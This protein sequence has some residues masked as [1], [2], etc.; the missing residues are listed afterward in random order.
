[1]P[2]G[3]TVER[4][5]TS[6]EMADALKSHFDKTDVCI[7]AAAISD[8]SPRNYSDE[9]IKRRDNGTLSIDL[10][11]NQDIAAE[12]AK[13]KKKQF[14][15]CFSLETGDD[16]KRAAEKMKKKGCDMM[17]LNSVDS[18][19]GKEMTSVSILYPGETPQKIDHMSKRECAQI[20]LSSIAEK[21]GFY[22]G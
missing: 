5:L 9:K 13:K 7:M 11:P 22:N 14:L 12:L 2:E 4:V 1:M 17:I 18:S 19:L 6:S 15:V 21:L 3:V 8:F 10:M 20:I 16:E